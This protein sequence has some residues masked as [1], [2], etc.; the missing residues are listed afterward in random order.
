MNENDQTDQTDQTDRTRNETVPADTQPGL[1]LST[2]HVAPGTTQDTQP[3]TTAGA[4]ISYPT[5]PPQ[6]TLDDDGP[7][8]ADAA[9]ARG[10]VQT[11]ARPD[12]QAAGAVAAQPRV[13]RSLRVR[14][15]VF[16]LV[17]LAIS[18]VSLVALLTD[19]RVDGGIV[20]LGLL[21]G[22]GA[23]LVAGGVAAA[24]REARGGPGATR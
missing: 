3:V 21:I 10:T 13:K 23:A 16:G 24:M 19:V 20:G 9:D 1:D 4:T 18:V 2:Q 5:L 8:A 15:A 7:D 11:D 12:V 14:T 22:A 17:M 6:F